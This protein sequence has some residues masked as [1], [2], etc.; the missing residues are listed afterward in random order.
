MKFKQL[1]N[2]EKLV[3]DP[4]L[5]MNSYWTLDKLKDELNLLRGKRKKLE[6][7]VAKKD[8]KP[9]AKADL[10]SIDKDISSIQAAINKKL[11]DDK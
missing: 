5:F 8:G 3:R 10:H 9:T 6:P 11:K 7:E 1:F 4:K 2:E